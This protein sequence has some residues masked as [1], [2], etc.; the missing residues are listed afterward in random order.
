MNNYPYQQMSLFPQQQQSQ[1]TPVQY[2]S[3]VA[4]SPIVW[5]TSEDVPRNYPVQPGTTVY[6]MNENEPYFYMKSAD[7]MGRP[8]FRKSRLIDET[9]PKDQ[10][11]NLDGYIKREEIHNIISDIVQQEVEKKMSEITLRPARKQKQVVIEEDE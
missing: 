8:T 6:F 11:I 9:E 5:V 7:S 1:Y 4:Q 3:T 10:T 2:Q